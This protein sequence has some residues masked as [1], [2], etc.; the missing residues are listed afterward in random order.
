[1]TADPGGTFH[2]VPRG[3]GIVVAFDRRRGIRKPKR[4]LDLVVAGLLLVAT[5]PLLGVVYLLVRMSSPG[6]A[7]FRQTR[8]GRGG[9]PFDL[10]KFRTMYVHSDETPHREYVRRLLAGVAEP[11]GGLYKLAA[12]ERVT[13]VGALLRRLSIDELPQLINVLRGEMSLVGPRP[14]LPWEA[15]M[16]PAWAAPRSWV[17]PGLTGLWQVSGR[18]ELTMLEGLRL[19]VEYVARQSLRVDLAILV[20]TVPTVL[21]A[22]GR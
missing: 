6:P 19:D 18:N 2:P 12:D 17:P 15:A 3:E 21:A 4:A 16:F 14:A 8:L 13:R 20:R 11:H 22:K 7:L 1:M 9:K 10:L 5:S